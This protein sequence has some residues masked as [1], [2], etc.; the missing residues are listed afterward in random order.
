[1]SALALSIG[2]ALALAGAGD[3][4]ADPTL[5]AIGGDAVQTRD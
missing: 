1:M 2:A 4:P 3:A 5:A